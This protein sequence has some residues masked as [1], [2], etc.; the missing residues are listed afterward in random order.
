MYLHAKRELLKKIKK[1]FSHLWKKTFPEAFHIRQNQ[2]TLIGKS[3]LTSLLAN[4]YLD[5]LCT[6]FQ[7]VSFTF[8]TCLQTQ[9][10]PAFFR[11]LM[12]I[13]WNYRLRHAKI[14]T[15]HL[16]YSSLYDLTRTEILRAAS[17]IPKQFFLRIW[18][19]LNKK[20]SFVAMRN[21]WYRF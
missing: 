9:E 10:F 21:I 16:T 8:F 19:N 20:S 12:V 15:K 5:R 1:Q 6:P 11:R 13:I 2:W 14:L 17:D 3:F 7:V 18:N 4:I